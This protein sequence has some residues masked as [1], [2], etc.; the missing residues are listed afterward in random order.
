MIQTSEA[1]IQKLK[2]STRN[3]NKY[4]EHWISQ[5]CNLT[6]LY[7]RKV[8]KTIHSWIMHKYW[9]LLTYIMQI[10]SRTAWWLHAIHFSPIYRETFGSRPTVRTFNSFC[11]TQSSYYFIIWTV[12][13]LQ[14]CF[15][16]FEHFNVIP[17]C[18]WSIKWIDSPSS[19]GK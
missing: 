14:N 18:L 4:W 2:I 17:L 10:Q 5:R 16:N 19:M 11:A 7:V 15:A 1:L 12:Q 9:W 3:I 8:N 6:S 13:I